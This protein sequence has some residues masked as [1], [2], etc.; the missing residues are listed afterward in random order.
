MTQRVMFT[1]CPNGVVDDGLALSVFIAPKLDPGGAATTLGDFPDFVD[2]PSVDIRWEVALGNEVLTAE[3][4]SDSP[5]SELWGGLFSA[6]TPVLPHPFH[7]FTDHLIYSYPAGHI[8]DMITSAYRQ[9]ALDHPIQPPPTQDLLDAD[10]P[11]DVNTDLHL[12]PTAELRR[13]VRARMTNADVRAIPP[14]APDPSQDYL[15]LWNFHQPGTMTISPD[16]EAPEFDFAQAIAMLGGHYGLLRRLG[17]VYDLLVPWDGGAAATVQVRPEWASQLGADSTDI[18]PVT[19]CILDAERFIPEPLDSDGIVD[20]V[21]PIANPTRYR[22]IQVDQD[23]GALNLSAMKKSLL[24][25]QGHP[26]ADTPQNATLPGLQSVGFQVAR[27]GQATALADHLDRSAALNQ[28]ITAGQEPELFAEDITPGTRWEVWTSRTGTWHPL[29]HRISDYEFLHL[30]HTEQISEEASINEVPTERHDDTDEFGGHSL[31]M[32]ET[33][34]RWDGWSLSVP[35]P[36]FTDLPDGTVGPPPNDLPDGLPLA[37]NSAV[38]PGTLPMLRYGVDY[39][40]RAR[41][42]DLAGNS[43]PFPTGPA[44][45]PG[46]Q[47]YLR[48][49]PIASPPVLLRH[50]RTEGE[51][52]EHVVLRSNYDTDP[53]GPAER[54]IV[55]PR[56]SQH[57]AERHGMFD[58]DDGLDPL[59]YAQIVARESESLEPSP[60][61]GGVDDAR[62]GQPYFPDAPLPVLH[63]PDPGAIGLSLRRM[64]GHPAEEVGLAAFGAP[65]GWP[66]AHAIRLVVEEGEPNTEIEHVDDEPPLVR[67]R[68]PKAGEAEMRYSSYV[69]DEHLERTAV[70]EMI[71]SSPNAPVGERRDQ[72][73]AGL[74]WMI[75]PARRLSFV[76]AVRQPLL[77]P[78][79]LDLAALR[80]RGETVAHLNGQLGFSEISTARVD[81]HASWTEIVDRGTGGGSAAPDPFDREHRDDLEIPVRTTDPEHPDDD[82]DTLVVSQLGHEFHDTKR[83]VITY[84]AEATSRF[85]EYFVERHDVELVETAAVPLPAPEGIVDRSETVRSLA[86]DEATYTRGT[87]YEIDYATAEIQRVADGDISD[88]ETVEV[89]FLP[90]P[91][92]RVSAEADTDDGRE[93]TLDIPSAARPAAPKV[94]YVIP[95][96]RWELRTDVRGADARSSVKSGGVRI[97]LDRPFFD[98]G[99]G[100]LLGVV[101]DRSPGAPSP[102]LE[103]YTTRWGYDPLQQPTAPVRPANPAPPIDIFPLHKAIGIDRLLAENGHQVNVV[104]HEVEFDSDRKLWFCDVEFELEGPD[105]TDTRM[106]FIRLALASYQ[107]VSVDDLHLSRVVLADIIQLTSARTA[108]LTI[109]GRDAALN[110]VGPSQQTPTLV[111]AQLESR[112]D[113]EDDMLDWRAVPGPRTDITLQAVVDIGTGQWSW[114]GTLRLP[115]PRSGSHDHLRIVIEEWRDELPGRQL[116][117]RDIIPVSR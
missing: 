51:S 70:W 36:G 105:L 103:P 34:I 16:D 17:L 64:P 44:I 115:P 110:V 47:T 100:Q 79:F 113:G 114:N 71:T 89:K 46:P 23:S 29:Q 20:G 112:R 33:L 48:Y 11:W 80:G 40:F 49:E 45:T 99:V 88:G 41:T 58:T 10:L 93:R 7:G 101:L 117:Y 102:D 32:Q 50:P 52:V 91:T 38:E 68:L 12:L 59:A 73:K 66:H 14:G 104:G 21:L 31:N 63:L 4:V 60:A 69:D 81:L 57:A 77:P 5:S 42:V 9:V 62:T 85:T 65:A 98:T 8:A 106:P 54:H 2:W 26:A 55:P 96:Q 76:H 74:L 27:T 56:T 18:R 92:T 6:D 84:R 67:V 94:L 75:T 35:R 19:R 108:T 111:T 116:I 86:D 83:R 109:S 43:A 90:K 87:D 72:A 25:A 107:P 3:V 15:Q 37:M 97:Y 24:Q 53:H 13:Q 28:A 78:V 1:A 30:N 39:R 82:H 95:T 61:N 22:I